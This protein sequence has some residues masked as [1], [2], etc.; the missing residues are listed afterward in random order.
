[1]KNYSV[2]RVVQHNGEKVGKFERHIER[3]NEH[4][5]NMNV[6]LSRTPMN[7]H[8]RDCGDLTYNQY[9]DK[10]VAD[11]K[12]SLR[13]LKKNAKVYDE[14]IFDVNTYYFEKH[15]G[16]EFAKR[17]YEEAFHFAEKLYGGQ[18]ILSAVLHADEVNLALSDSYGYP[19]YHYH[20]HIMAL[21]VVEKQV[22]W[23]KRC[24]DKALVGTVKET[25]WQVSHSKKWKSPQAVDE[26]GKP[27][28]NKNG[29]PVLV[30][31]YS[32]LQD[33]FFEHMQAAGFGDF[34]R[35]ER[36]STDENLTSL[37]FQISK[38]QERL[39]AIQEKI[40]TV[41]QEF[42]KIEPVKLEIDEVAAIG[43]RSLTGKVQ[44]SQEDYGKL[45]ELA[46]EGITSRKRIFDLENTVSNM[47]EHIR[48]LEYKL[49]ELTEKCKPYL[50]A[51]QSSPKRVKEFLDNLL[52][53]KEKPVVKPSPWDVNVNQLKEKHPPKKKSKGDFER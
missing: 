37:Q 42:T 25:V 28:I 14:L 52:K 21:P 5:A 30:P 3:K 33:E 2:A 34:D 18:N 53:P 4:Y 11:G 31:S 49:T 50:E 10:L 17:F 38:D 27:A 7:V 29:K 23:S 6:D 47:R 15:G 35:G 45:T 41:T 16:Y 51:L 32:I 9:L 24:K 26:N 39:A 1:M 13:G 36:G 20:M 12:V 22:L 19:V 8:F 44:M 43:K 46:K 40:D 48:T